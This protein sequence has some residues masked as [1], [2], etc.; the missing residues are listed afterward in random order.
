[1][2]FGILTKSLIILK[3]DGIKNNF[4]P[5]LNNFW[6]TLNPADIRK[7]CGLQKYWE[8]QKMLGVKR[9]QLR[10]VMSSTTVSDGDVCPCI[11]LSHVMCNFT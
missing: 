2:F 8:Q 11:M 3:N 7:Y 6:C 10:T 1:M 4:P 5:V 9:G